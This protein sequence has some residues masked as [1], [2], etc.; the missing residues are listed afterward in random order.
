MPEKIYN[1]M[2]DLDFMDY[3]E[4]KEQDLEYIAE[5]LKDH[6]FDEVLEILSR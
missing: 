4:T 2:L 1:I 3:T 5:L 6:T